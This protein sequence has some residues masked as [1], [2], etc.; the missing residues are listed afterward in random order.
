MP[1]KTQGSFVFFLVHSVTDLEFG[2]EA[3]ERRISYSNNIFFFSSPLVGSSFTSCPKRTCSSKDVGISVVVAAGF[4]IALLS[5]LLALALF[6]EA[7]IV[8]LFETTGDT[9]FGDSVALLVLLLAP[10][11]VVVV[12]GVGAILVTEEFMLVVVTVA[13]GVIGALLDVFEEGVAGDL[14][15]KTSSAAM[16]SRSVSSYNSS[17]LLYRGTKLSW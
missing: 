11:I 5:L 13:T 7:A 17:F 16:I 15:S 9:G 12:V 2:S 4:L 1:Y 3:S 14:V 6:P 10:L 8:L